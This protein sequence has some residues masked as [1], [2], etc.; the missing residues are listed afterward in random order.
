M[1][2]FEGFDVFKQNNQKHIIFYS[3]VT[4]NIEIEFNVSNEDLDLSDYEVVGRFKKNQSEAG[5]EILFLESSSS[6]LE[7][8]H[9]TGLVENAG[10]TGIIKLS[11]DK[12]ECQKLATIEEEGTFDIRAEKNDDIK[13]LIK[14]TW[15]IIL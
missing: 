6:N 2:V 10:A 11:I 12:A 4:I 9:V 14:G 8:K 7:N 3:G 13:I 5:N 15:E 1:G